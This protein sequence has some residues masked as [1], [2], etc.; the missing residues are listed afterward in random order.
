MSKDRKRLIMLLSCII[1]VLSFALI[2]LNT[3]LFKKT[4]VGNAIDSS[5]SDNIR[6]YRDYPS[7][8]MENNIYYYAT[9]DEI[10]EVLTKG[11]GIVFFG[12]PACPYCQAYVPVLDEVAR[13]RDVQKIYYLN[14]KEMRKQETDE[15]KK[16]VEI[17]S[18]YLEVDENG[19]KRI[20][21][22]DAYFVKDG[23]IVGHN[24]SMSTLSGVDV[25]E[26]FNETRRKELKTQLIELTEMIYE[27]VC[28][29][30]TVNVY[31]C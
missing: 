15:Y 1:L 2:Y 3:D 16:L 6:F 7:V 25:K 13:E 10:V 22:P 27:P 28:D 8:D 14:I 23:K 18:D 11:T 17:L 20:Y 26:Y 21:V 24:N 9:Y 5:V 30:K 12:F 19:V 31:G 29:D 4:E